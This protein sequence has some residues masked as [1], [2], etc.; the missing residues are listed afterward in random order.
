MDDLLEK[1]KSIKGAYEEALKTFGDAMVLVDRENKVLFV[2]KEASEQF[3]LVQGEIAGKD[4]VE[5]TPASNLIG[6]IDPMARPSTAATMTAQVKTSHFIIHM[7]GSGE[8]IVATVTATPIILGDNVAG[9]I[10]VLKKSDLFKNL[11]N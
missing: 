6:E 8:K 11:A 9:G 10:L 7:A 5:E 4:W 2:N 3:G 1:F